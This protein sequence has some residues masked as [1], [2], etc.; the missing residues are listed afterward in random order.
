MSA[1]ASRRTAA[2]DF[3]TLSPIECLLIA[4]AAHEFGVATQSW[5]TISKLMA[6]HPLVSRPKN[7]FTPSL[8]GSIYEHLMKEAQLERTDAS[9]S[10]KAP[11][12]LALAQKHFQIRFE[13][14]MTLIKA[15]ETKFRTVM[16]EIEDIK[17]GKW[18]SNLKAKMSG[19][20]DAKAEI[21]EPGNSAEPDEDT[22]GQK[23]EDEEPEQADSESVAE[24]VPDQDGQDDESEEEQPS[25]EVEE[26]ETATQA[27][28]SI[29]DEDEAK[30]PASNPEDEDGADDEVQSLLEVDSEAGN[31]AQELSRTS[32][33]PSSPKESEQ[34]QE[35][36]GESSA[37]EPLQTIR[38]STRRKSSA[39]STAPPRPRTRRQRQKQ[40]PA[41]SEPET[42]IAVKAETP[43]QDEEVPSSPYEG[44]ST[45]ARE[46]K[47]KASFPDEV[48]RESKRIRE[49]SELP[50]ED[51]S[52][53]PAR[54]RSTRQGK[55]PSEQVPNKKFQNVIGL[56]HQQISAHRNGTIFHNPIKV[57]DAPDYH[58]IVKRPMDLKTIKAR[59]KDGAI[60]NSREFQ[61]DTYLMFANAMMYNRPGSDVYTMAEDMMLDSEM[62][63]MNFKQTEG[64]RAQR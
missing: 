43:Q 35:E 55:A 50:E 6:K 5:S 22:T 25:Q 12:N 60:S 4:Q 11:E 47:R 54:T 17:S 20:P 26:E 21:E 38:R 23:Q 40:E 59:V 63:I 34:P 32:E 57:S 41:D 7:F 52:A 18:D 1:R 28:A 42:D 27:A 56:L 53:T 10:P 8:C 64:F 29:I 58:E 3:S 14:L 33:P 9:N 31:E 39:A 48:A 13:E 37:D 62:Q 44:A 15:E 61:R 51:E 2:F 24:E 46:G 16:K 30:V 45:R 49:D 19:V 36:G